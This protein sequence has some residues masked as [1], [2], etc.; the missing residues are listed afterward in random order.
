MG[1]ESKGDWKQNES[2]WK[3]NHGDW[4]ENHG[5][6]KENHGGWKESKERRENQE[7]WK[8]NKDKGKEDPGDWKENKGNWK[9][10]NG[11][12]KKNRVDWK[13]NKGNDGNW[14]SK[15]GSANWN[16]PRVNSLA[17]QLYAIAG[18]VPKNDDTAVTHNDAKEWALEK[19][20]IGSIGKELSSSEEG[21]ASDLDSG[22]WET[23][24]QDWSEL[25]RGTAIFIESKQSLLNTL[26]VHALYVQCLFFSEVGTISEVSL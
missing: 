11:D 15:S 10:I 7:D 2:D 18:T 9:E 12:L 13:E 16:E 4:E 14:N 26:S 17:K 6:W 20:K 24:H 22:R 1:K 21:A 23:S 5:D 25:G 3:E 19:T 8:E